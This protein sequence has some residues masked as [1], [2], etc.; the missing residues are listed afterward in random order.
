MRRIFKLRNLLFLALAAGLVAL[1]I[2]Q[3]SV[4][5]RN[6]ERNEAL[7]ENIQAAQQ[8][9]EDLEEEKSILGSDEYVER[10]ARENLGYVKSDE[11]VFVKEE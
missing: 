6:I 8:K 1:I 9:I 11:T 10:K 2:S 5:D 7:K 3:Q 4:L